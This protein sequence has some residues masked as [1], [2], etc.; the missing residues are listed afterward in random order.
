MNTM[1]V[2]G[3]NGVATSALKNAVVKAVK[4]INKA[5]IG[6]K[7]YVMIDEGFRLSFDGIRFIRGAKDNFIFNGK[8]EKK[9]SNGRYDNVFV[10]IH[11]KNLDNEEGLCLNDMINGVLDDILND[12]DNWIIDYYKSESSSKWADGLEMYQNFRNK[13]FGSILVVDNTK[14]LN[15]PDALIGFENASEECDG[16]MMACVDKY[17]Q[18][19]I[20]GVI[21]EYSDVVYNAVSD[22]DLDDTINYCVKGALDYM[23]YDPEKKR[24]VGCSDVPDLGN[25]D[26]EEE[27]CNYFEDAYSFDW[28][29]CQEFYQTYCNDIWHFADEYDERMEDTLRYFNE[30]SIFDK[31]PYTINYNNEGYINVYI[32][33]DDFVDYIKKNMIFNVDMAQ[34]FKYE[35]LGLRLYNILD[36]DNEDIKQFYNDLISMLPMVTDVKLYDDGLYFWYDDMTIREYFEKHKIDDGWGTYVTADPINNYVDEFLSPDA[37]KTFF[38]LVEK[39]EDWSFYIDEDADGD[40][41]VSGNEGIYKNYFDDYVPMIQ[42]YSYLMDKMKDEISK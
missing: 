6:K 30:E 5:E 9:G 19:F 3:Q 42:V 10:E 36:P 24:L 20:D 18:E 1:N 27:F 12:I 14:D 17:G 35:D 13:F 23:E 7:T 21:K 15:S 31:M 34:L 33:M 38:N 26:D 16:N 39:D 29:S 32:D 8:I 22:Y 25:W 4:M 11:Y 37:V 41:Y 28:D 40:L 2:N